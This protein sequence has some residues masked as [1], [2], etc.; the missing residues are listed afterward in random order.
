[1]WLL[2]ERNNDRSLYFGPFSTY[3]EA[4]AYRVRRLS[5]ARDVSIE[6]M[7]EI[8]PETDVQQ[9]L[10][11]DIAEVVRAQYARRPAPLARSQDT[12]FREALERTPLP[13]SPAGRYGAN[14]VK[15]PADALRG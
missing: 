5:A 8:E 6:P 11:R 4:S 9:Q 15:G 7:I 14:Q 12:S 10:E 1:M 3:H 13:A 2:S